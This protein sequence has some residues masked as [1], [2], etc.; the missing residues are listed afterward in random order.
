MVGKPLQRV[1]DSAAINNAGANAANAVPEVQAADSFRVSG[2]DPAESDQN[3]ADAQHEPRPD[4]VDQITLKGYQPGFERDEQRKRPLHRD[5]RNMQMLLDGF[6]EQ[7]PG[8]LQVRDSH[9]R[10][11][12]R[13][14]LDP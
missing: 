4:L 7:R 8:I 2:A 6:G 5:Q 12:A 1:A 11:D 14:E 3:R 9:H 13:G 10:D